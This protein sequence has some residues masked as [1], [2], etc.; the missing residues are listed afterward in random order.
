[1]ASASSFRAQIVPSRLLVLGVGTSMVVLC[2]AGIVVLLPGL[3]ARQQLADDLRKQ[4]E[5][6]NTLPDTETEPD[7]E[8]LE[9]ALSNMAASV[10]AIPDLEAITFIAVD[11]GQMFRYEGDRTRSIDTLQDPAVWLSL[12]EGRRIIVDETDR[13]LI[14]DPLRIPGQDLAMEMAV[15]RDAYLRTEAER[16]VSIV[17]GG[18]ILSA[19]MGTLLMLRLARRLEESRGELELVLESTQEPV[20]M[21]DGNQRLVFANRPA[22][23]LL[24]KGVDERV[25]GAPLLSLCPTP[26]TA[27]FFT[28]LL[29][30]ER[31]SNNEL[32][33]AMPGYAHDAVFR[34]QAV[35]VLTEVGRSLGNLLVLR[36]V[37]LEKRLEDR[38][39]SQTIHELKGMLGEATGFIRQVVHRLPSEDRPENQMYLNLSL[40]KLQHCYVT[41]A[42]MVRNIASAFM[43]EDLDLHP[44]HHDLSELVRRNVESFRAMLP[45]DQP[46]ARVD[47]HA[48]DHLAAVYCD[49]EAISRIVMNLMRNAHQHCP[50]GQIDVRLT[51]NGSHVDVCIEDTGTGIAPEHLSRIFEPHESFRRGG[52]GMGLSVCRDFVRAQG[53]EIWAD[54]PGRGQGAR[55]TFSLPRSQ[56]VILAT[57][58]VAVA[59]FR[60]RCVE[61]GYE[62][63]VI[64]DLLTVVKQVVDL[65]PNFILLDLDL[66]G[67]LTGPSLAYRLK[68]SELVGRVPIVA[69]AA[70][71]DAAREAIARYDGLELDAF[72][73]RDC[74]A[75]NFAS[76]V[77][78]M[79]AYWYVSQTV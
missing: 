31:P 72:L 54:S 36:N 14:Y 4:V 46:H 67:T 53:G 59:H 23:L 39:V 13:Y 60:M 28:S 11:S 10:T 57:D 69:V 20:I 18:I 27:Q 26:E 48:P 33:A 68:R 47:L 55:F 32:T 78:I 21:V 63:I 49:S 70:D 22:R 42:T 45:E 71:L 41:V 19:L 5:S 12:R 75:A 7:A 9:R 79:D 34:G 40:E 64:K 73:V 50:R 17:V 52:T 29:L 38:R 35:P 61:T 15:G 44:R 58:H 43:P 16:N 77:Q 37:T 74:D 30:D 1:M 51:E 76:V 66:S 24:G 25:V 6:V 65:H 3:R 8:A 62:P 2:V 56:P